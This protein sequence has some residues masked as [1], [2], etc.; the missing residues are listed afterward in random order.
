MWGLSTFNPET[1][2]LSEVKTLCLYALDFYITLWYRSDYW[3][4]FC[5]LS[6]QADCA[7]GALIFEQGMGLGMVRNTS[8]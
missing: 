3:Y 4:K 7:C 8:P 1:L 5:G 2:P 6:R